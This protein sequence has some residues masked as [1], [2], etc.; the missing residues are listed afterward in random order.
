MTYKYIPDF[1]NRYDNYI[2]NLNLIY[3]LSPDVEKYSLII[4]VMKGCNKSDCLSVIFF[5]L[6]F[7]VKNFSF[8]R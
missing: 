4:Q 7:L 2:Y 8:V 1:I 3:V 5:F 6:F